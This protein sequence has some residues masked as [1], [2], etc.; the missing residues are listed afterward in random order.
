MISFKMK[1]EWIKSNSGYNGLLLNASSNR[2]PLQRIQCN[3]ESQIG[4]LIFFMPF[5]EL[6]KFSK[7]IKKFFLFTK[8][9]KLMKESINGK[10]RVCALSL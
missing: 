5:F 7:N 10:M 6:Q 4:T 2:E 1:Y 9:F 8:N 3:D